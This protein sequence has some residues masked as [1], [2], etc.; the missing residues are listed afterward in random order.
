M[1]PPPENVIRTDS[2]AV[3]G[4]QRRGALNPGRRPGLADRGNVAARAPGHGQC[5]RDGQAGGPGTEA[6]DDERASNPRED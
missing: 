6:A 1:L 5:L 3:P 4:G 2:C